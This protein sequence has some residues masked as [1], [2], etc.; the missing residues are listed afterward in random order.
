MHLKLGLNLLDDVRVHVEGLCEDVD[1]DGRLRPENGVANDDASRSLAV[2][3]RDS[4]RHCQADIDLKV[5][6]A[7]GEHK[8]V[9][10]DEDFDDELVVG[11]YEAHEE[12]ALQDEEYLGGPGVDVG[13]VQSARRE[14]NALQRYS[15]Q[16]EP[17]EYFDVNGYYA[18]SES[19]WCVSWPVEP[20]EEEIVRRDVVRVLAEQTTLEHCEQW[21]WGRK[22]I[23]AS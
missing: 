9:A 17:R 3:S 8:D 4:Y 5:D 10:P 19:V 18:G 6:E 11:G 20:T 2:Q 1:G 7:L 21:W 13:R 15:Q 14:V 12:G 16:V 22:K 23:A